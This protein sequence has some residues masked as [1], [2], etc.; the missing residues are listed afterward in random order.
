MAPLKHEVLR[1]TPVSHPPRAAVSTAAT[2]RS[3][4]FPLLCNDLGMSLTRFLA[5]ALATA[6]GE[7]FKGPW[8]PARTV[9]TRCALPSQNYSFIGD[10]RRCMLEH[11]GAPEGPWKRKNCWIRRRSHL[12]SSKS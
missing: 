10:G 6:P 9:P 4:S 5:A 11:C 7:D 8:S 3:R 12:L 1:V 2:A